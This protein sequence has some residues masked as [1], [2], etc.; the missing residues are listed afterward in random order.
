MATILIRSVT[1]GFGCFVVNR[2]RLDDGNGNGD[3]DDDDDNCP[4]V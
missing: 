1:N 3:D 2:S 4:V